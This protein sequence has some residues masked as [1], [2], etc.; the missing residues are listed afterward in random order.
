MVGLVAALGFGL[1]SRFGQ[2]RPH[3][4]LPSLLGSG[5][6]KLANPHK[7]V[8]LL[9]RL[10]GLELLQGIGLWEGLGFRVVASVLLLPFW[11][12]VLQC[13]LFSHFFQSLGLQV[14]N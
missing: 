3:S 9:K 5:C 13:Y 12:C 4:V 8:T 11:S 1:C 2:D 10:R 7:H 6:V 14:Y